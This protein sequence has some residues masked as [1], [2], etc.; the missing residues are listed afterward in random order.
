MI[1][2]P[3]LYNTHLTNNWYVNAF[4]AE[5]TKRL[6]N[7]PPPSPR[8]N[9]PHHYH[10]YSPTRHPSEPVEPYGHFFCG[11]EGIIG[12]PLPSLLPK[13]VQAIEHLLYGL[14]NQNIRTTNRKDKLISP[15]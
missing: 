15:A 12:P 3:L 4:G 1:S 8:S 10:I 6:S 9:R 5:S 2:E 11:S 14:G 13:N 7:T